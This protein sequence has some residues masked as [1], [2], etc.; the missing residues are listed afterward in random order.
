MNELRSL[1]VDD[2]KLSRDFIAHLIDAYCPEISV[3][4]QCNS[5]AQAKIEIESNE[6]DLL[7]LDV[8]MPN[9][10]GFDL[11]NHFPN[12]TF[13][14]IFIS[15]FEQYAY[16]GFKVNALDYL[17]KPI[18]KDRFM[19]STYKAVL[20]HQNLNEVNELNVQIDMIDSHQALNSLLV[21]RKRGAVTIRIEDICYFEASNNYCIIHMYDGE[22]YVVT[23]TLKDYTHILNN[24][25]L[26]V[27]KSYLVNSQYISGYIRSNGIKIHLK[28]GT[29]IPVSRRKQGLFLNHYTP[30]L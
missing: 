4:A 8:E 13:K 28:T 12:P 9:E 15:A 27:H 21:P 26:R 30:N 5:A 1:I 3:I 25:F 14:V 2:D 24:D 10:T 17:S 19:A 18:E 29:I 6:V 20:S 22:Q 7:F 16:E 23:K 11:L